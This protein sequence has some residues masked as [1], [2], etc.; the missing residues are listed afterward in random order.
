M[1]EKI[2]AEQL[3]IDVGTVTDDKKR[4]ACFTVDPLFYYLYLQFL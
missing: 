4:K 2:I 1:I 3:K